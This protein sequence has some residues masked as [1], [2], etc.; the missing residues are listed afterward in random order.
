MEDRGAMRNVAIAGLA[1]L[2]LAGA[3]ASARATRRPAWLKKVIASLVAQPVANPPAKIV[4]YEHEG[5]RF[6]YVPPRCCDVP[7]V[8]Y[9]SGGTVVCRP[10]GGITGKGDGRC[11]SA[12]ESLTEGKVIW[13]DSRHPRRLKP[14]SGP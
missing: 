7:S 9:D 13:R 12:L 8:L 6:Y 11:P 3:P 10:D 4:R 1:M 5:Q 14:P 2:V